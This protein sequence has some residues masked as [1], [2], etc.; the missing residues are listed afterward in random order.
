[1]GGLGTAVHNFFFSPDAVAGAND[2]TCKPSSAHPYPVVLSHG[3]FANAGDNWV[4]LAPMLANQ[5]YCV[6]AFNFGMNHLSLGRVGGLDD[7][8]RSAATLSAF[9]DKVLASTG[10]RKVDIVGHSLGGMLPNYYLK[11][12]GGAD[13]VRTLVGMG[14]SNHGTTLS[15][16]VGLGRKLNALGFV[17]GLF[18]HAGL[19]SLKQ[20]ETG[21]DFQTDLWKDGDTVPGVRYVVIATEHDQ[22]VTPYANAFLHGDQV[23]NIRLQDQ[24]PKD[25]V[26]HIGLFLDSPTLQNIENALGPNTPGFTPTCSGYGPSF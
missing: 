19:T 26:G 2:W 11:R 14:P 1:M 17:N 7:N 24:C 20:Q 4:A 13:K 25:N 15:G 16:L 6:Y 22:V 3:T 10:A 9:V 8:V 18:D 5:G 12:L 21:S 23:T